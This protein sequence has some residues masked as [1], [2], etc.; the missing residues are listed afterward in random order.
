MK[1][2]AMILVAVLLSLPLF[3]AARMRSALPDLGPAAQVSLKGT[4]TDAVT[5]LPVAY[6]TIT[7]ANR[8]VITS[9]LGK[10]SLKPVNTPGDINVTAGR[11]GYSS[12]TIRLTGIGTQEVNFRLQSRPTASLK[13][14]D[15][16]T[17]DVD[18]DSVK[19]GYI[20]PFM[21]YQTSTGN[22]FCMNG[23]TQTRVAMADITRVTAS[24]TSVPGSCCQRPGARVLLELRDGTLN[25]AT[26]VDSCFGY[27]VDVIARNH[28]T[29]EYVYVPFSEVS[30]IDFP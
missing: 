20:V 27:T 30:E 9:S 23:A 5:G 26:F 24:G 7:V 14:V 18:D 16:T 22:L 1:R 29:G 11:T 19:F 13:K 10:F 6:A 4:V 15:G 21:N 2:F 8:S 25:D 17:L 3:A 12:S 28:S